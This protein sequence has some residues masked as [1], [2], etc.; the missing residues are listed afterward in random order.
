MKIGERAGFKK[1][2]S[3]FKNKK[4]LVVGDL[5]LD[6]FIWG[7]VSRISPEAP[8]PVVWAKRESF[9]PGGA[10]NVANNISSLGAK[11]YIIGTVGND[12]AGDT[13][14]KELERSGIETG[15]M[16]VERGRP[17]TLKTR[18]VAQNQQ[19]VRIDKE[20][21]DP[22]S[23]TVTAKLVDNVK[24]VIDQVDAVI[25][26]DYG[27]GVVTPGLLSK[28]IPLAKASRTMIAVD[29]KEEHFYDY[30]GASLIT[31]NQH[32]ASKLA[33]FNIADDAKLM[34]AGKRLLSALHCK[35]VLVTLGE[36]GMC[37]FQRGLKPRK[38]PT[39]AQEVYDVSG[40]GDTVIAVFTL[41]YVSGARPVAAARIAN[42]AA[43]IVVGKLGTAV[44]SPEELLNRIC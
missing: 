33:G 43:G 16:I 37:L 20:N 42:C 10:C 3:N 15:G 25:L 22:L 17:T 5:I 14:K 23:G 41:A 18:V 32:E 34:K 7:N 39:M 38:I 28:V 1:T 19:V 12:E 2:L 4:I 36:K 27:K 8:V 26:E 11:A 13:L 31:P 6:E 35:M 40:A 24:R 29:P 9:M 21:L 44:V 30:R